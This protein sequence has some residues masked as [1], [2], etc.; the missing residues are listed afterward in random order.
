MITAAIGISHHLFFIVSP[1]LIIGEWNYKT[2]ILY[3]FVFVKYINDGWNYLFWFLGT[4]FLSI[5]FAVVAWFYRGAFFFLP[6]AYY[7][8]ITI[9]DSVWGKDAYYHGN[10]P[11]PGVFV[12]YRRWFELDLSLLMIGCVIAILY[13]RVSIGF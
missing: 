7:A 4:I 9:Y 11:I 8:A 5:I 12:K 6:S 1:Y 13:R 10:Y 3:A 2:G